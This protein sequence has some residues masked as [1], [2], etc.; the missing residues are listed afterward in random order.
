MHELQYLLR[1]IS[2]ARQRKRNL[3]G[4]QINAASS[5]NYILK[6]YTHVV[7]NRHIDIKM[8]SPG[9]YSGGLGDA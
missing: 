2:I 1:I 9:P 8:G 6:N 3:R 4:C 7:Q 5:A